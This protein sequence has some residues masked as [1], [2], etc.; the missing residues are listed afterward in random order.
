MLS[1]HSISRIEVTLLWWIFFLVP[2]VIWFTC[3][4]LPILNIYS[5]WL[6]DCSCVCA[7]L[8]GIRIIMDLK[9]SVKVLVFLFLKNNLRSIGCRYYWKFVIILLRIHLCLSFFQLE[10]F[11]F[12]FQPSIL[13]W[14][15]LDCLCLLGLTLVV[16]MNLKIQSFLLDISI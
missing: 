16:L 14:V 1:H 3:I 15:C 4:L 5:S 7:L 6:L 12:L 9:K 11:L 8:F 13:L 2:I 10:W